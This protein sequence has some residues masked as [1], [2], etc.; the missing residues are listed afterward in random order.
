MRADPTVTKETLNIHQDSYNLAPR[1]GLFLARKHDI[2][3]EYS[4][5][6]IVPHT[7]RRFLS[8]GNRKARPGLW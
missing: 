2:G 8:T 5:D 4:C 3:S 1:D 6:T 7:V